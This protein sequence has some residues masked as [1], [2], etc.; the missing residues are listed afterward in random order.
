MR[1]VRPDNATF[2]SDGDRRTGV[3]LTLPDIFYTKIARIELEPERVACEFDNFCH[4]NA[5]V[6]EDT[7]AGERPITFPGA[8][9]RDMDVQFSHYTCAGR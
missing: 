9:S 4:G 7:I 1:N 2:S 5:G 6:I 8:E 3:S